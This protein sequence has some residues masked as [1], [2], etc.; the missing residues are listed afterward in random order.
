MGM[1]SMRAALPFVGMVMVMLAQVSNMEVIKAAM[2]RG[3]NKYVV[4]VYSDALSSLFFL[5]C[6]SITHR[7]LYLS[8]PL[9]SLIIKCLYLLSTDAWCLAGQSVRHSHSPFSADSS[10]FRF[11]GQLFASSLLLFKFQVLILFYNHEA[12]FIF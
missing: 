12:N 1:C 5:L 4:I 7:S 9:S 6:S 8:R 10:C 11:L 3:I 2:S